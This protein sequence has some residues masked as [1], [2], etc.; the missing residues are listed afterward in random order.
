MEIVRGNDSAGVGGGDTPSPVTPSLGEGPVQ[1]M[2]ASEAEPKPKSSPGKVVASK[3]KPTMSVKPPAGKTNGGPP[4]PLVKRIINSG[5]FGV[6]SVKPT[7]AKTLSAAAPMK[8]VTT[9]SALVLKKSTSGSA[10]QAKPAAPTSRAPSAPSAVPSRRLSMVPPKPAPPLEKPSLSASA[11]AKPPGSSN[12]P[13]ASVVSPAGSAGS[14]ASRPRVSVSESVKKTPMTSRQSI[15]ATKPPPARS[16]TSGASRPTRP[17]TASISSIKEVRE[18]GKVLD[19]LQA[20]LKDAIETLASKTE[21]VL[22]LEGQVGQLSSSLDTALADVESKQLLVRDLKKDKS[23]LEVQLNEVKEALEKLELEYQDTVSALQVVHRDLESAKSN[24]KTQDELVE[25]LQVQIQGLEVEA[26]SAKENLEALQASLTSE[27]SAAA[28]ADNE[29]LLT[30]Q[31]K[32]KALEGAAEL[33][34]AEHATILQDVELQ[35]KTL[36]EKG[37]L[38]EELSAQVIRLKK[39][40]EDNSGKLSEL[41]IEIL[42][43][44]ESQE[45]IEDERERSLASIKSLEEQLQKATFA[46]QQA[47]NDFKA[48][49]TDLAAQLEQAEDTYRGS[50]QAVSEEHGKLT[51]TLETLQKE[52]AESQAAWDEANAYAQDA[53]GQH[54]MELKQAEQGYIEKQSGLMQEIEKITLELKSQESYYNSKVNLV[55]EE[56]EKLLQEAFERAKSEAGEQHAQELQSLRSTSSA[57]VEQIQAMNQSSVEAMKAEHASIMDSEVKGLEK[58][59]NGLKLDLKAT[60]DDLMKAKAA[61]EVARTEV[62]SLTSQRDQ[63]RAVSASARET[64]PEHVEELARLAQ[65]LAIKKDDLEA[66]TGLLDLT[67]ASLTEISNNQ[68]KELEEAAKSRAEEVTKLR[69]AHDAT[70][71]SVIAEKTA[72]ANNLSDVQGELATLKASISSETSPPRG[73]GNGSVHPPSPGVTKEELQRMHE[74]HNLKIHDLQAEHEKALKALRSELEASEDRTSEL[75]QEVG[76]KAME[77]QYLEQDQEENQEQITRY[78]GF[79]RLKGFIGAVVALAVIYGFI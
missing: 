68:V 41:E 57:T 75:Q 55:K 30:A 56:H 21:A 46:A 19:E 35:L 23:L 37:M 25:K 11:S 1:P 67:K 18:D 45:V 53:A 65:E 54:T 22:A 7:S 44:K 26:S 48:R 62:K 64:P 76:R 20:K 42:E 27:A 51:S 2:S 4:T 43:L 8:P 14:S 63:A 16:A 49:E 31:T 3:T 5:T 24:A 36:Q 52:L 79:F 60:Q 73:N 6:G 78:V 32:I 50:L 29:A 28:L 69:S 40:K 70:L 66:V 59:I 38:A 15:V 72:L 17:T 71:M 10:I 39:E 77:I 47:D 61:L 9:T 58:Q 12:T 33:A 34:K 13:R 74:A